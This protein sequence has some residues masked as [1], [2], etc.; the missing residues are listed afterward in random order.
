M[1]FQAP[2]RAGIAEG[3]WQISRNHIPQVGV[4]GDISS[5]EENIKCFHSDIQ[6]VWLLNNSD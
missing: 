6:S 2:G 3:F 5:C 4:F 1:P